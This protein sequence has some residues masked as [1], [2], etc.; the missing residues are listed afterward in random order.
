MAQS[1][2]AAQRAGEGTSYSPAPSPRDWSN[3][4]L[5]GCGLRFSNVCM[6]ICLCTVI[7][8]MCTVIPV[9]CTVIHVMWTA[10][11]IASCGR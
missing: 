6:F 3:R 11:R 4:M 7:P 2:N 10:G 5:D 9:M 8:V 1:G